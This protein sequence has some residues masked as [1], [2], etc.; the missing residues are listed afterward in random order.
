MTGAFKC[1]KCGGAT[2]GDLKNCPRCGESLVKECKVCGAS[3]RYIWDYQC[4]PA[5]GAKASR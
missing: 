3:W 1:P 2:W 4:C 5:C